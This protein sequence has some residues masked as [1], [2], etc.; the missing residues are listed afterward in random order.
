MMMRNDDETHVM[1]IIYFLQISN[2]IAEG[3]LRVDLKTGVKIF[4]F[5]LLLSKLIV[6]S[7][8]SRGTVWKGNKGEAKKVEYFYNFAKIIS[9]FV[10]I[11][12]IQIKKKFIVTQITN[13]P[14]HTRQV[15]QKFLLFISNHQHR[16]FIISSSPEAASSYTKHFTSK[17]L[18]VNLFFLSSYARCG[19]CNRHFCH[20]IS[21]FFRTETNDGIVYESYA[22][23]YSF[24]RIKKKAFHLKAYTTSKKINFTLIKATHDA[25]S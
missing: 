14:K 22:R 6:E 1:S 3:K 7:W 2:I 10:I 9:S 24:S 23:I 15:I 21:L 20:W 19:N 13:C 16:I 18:W 25:H 12:R 8:E 17:R 5:S 4:C 11:N